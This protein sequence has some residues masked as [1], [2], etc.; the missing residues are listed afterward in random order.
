MASDP[1]GDARLA[2]LGHELQSLRMR[3]EAVRRG[4]VVDGPAP[5]VRSAA[6]GVPSAASAAPSATV[7]VPS[8]AIPPGPPTVPPQGDDEVLARL[9]GLLDELK[10]VTGE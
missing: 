7:G 2:G 5:A 6:P 8:A 9:R 3:L 4:I 1:H 10:A